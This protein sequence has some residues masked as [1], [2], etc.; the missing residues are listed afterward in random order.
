M[1]ASGPRVIS[2]RPLPSSKFL[3]TR[4]ASVRGLKENVAGLPSI[5]HVKQVV[6]LTQPDPW[7]IPNAP[8]KK[9]SV[10]IYAYLAT[11]HGGKL[12]PPAAEKGLRLYDEYVEEAR[13]QPGSHP[14]I[15]LL[16]QVIQDR[17]EYDIVVEH[18]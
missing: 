12:T 13:N 8:G 14:N 2:N 17:A 10:A 11:A 3:S 16:F 1:Q 9:A 15:D 5:D 6:V 4:S 7:T 18:E